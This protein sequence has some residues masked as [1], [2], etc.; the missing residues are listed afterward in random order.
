MQRKGHRR[1]RLADELERV[2]QTCLVI[3]TSKQLLRDSKKVL[4]ENQ[5]LRKQMRELFRNS[6]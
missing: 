4:A 1:R 3:E 5:R 6:K 2:E